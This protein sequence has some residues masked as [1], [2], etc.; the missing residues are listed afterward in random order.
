MQYYE[1]IDFILNAIDIDIYN[2][3]IFDAIYKED[4]LRAI[5]H[6]IFKEEDRLSISLSLSNKMHVFY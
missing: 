5:D 1:L 3:K 2:A 6:L 4:M